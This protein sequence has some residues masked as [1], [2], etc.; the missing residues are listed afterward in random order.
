MFGLHIYTLVVTKL[1]SFVTFKDIEWA[2]QI[3]I[4]FKD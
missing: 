2:V 4:S 3:T 1:Q